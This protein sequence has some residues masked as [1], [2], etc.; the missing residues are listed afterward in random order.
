MGGPIDEKIGKLIDERLKGGKTAMTSEKREYCPTCGAPQDHR[1]IQT[2]LE[3][4]KDRHQHDMEKLAA[5][6][7]TAKQTYESA[8]A[9]LANALKSL[10]YHIENYPNGCRDGENCPTNQALH[11]IAQDAKKN[12][13]PDDLSIEL[14]AEWLRERQA[15]GVVKHPQTGEDTIFKGIKVGGK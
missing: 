6:R 7:D 3:I 13:A 12:L 1:H 5:E 2:D 11:R 14:V 9:K 10:Q 4:E 15:M 8:N